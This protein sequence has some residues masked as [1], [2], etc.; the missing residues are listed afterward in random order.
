[1]AGA[2]ISWLRAH[3]DTVAGMR[4]RWRTL[5]ASLAV[6]VLAG[7]TSS[8]ED[9]AQPTLAPTAESEDQLE[10]IAERLDQFQGF[11]GDG[12]LVSP[13]VGRGST[14]VPD[15][16]FDVEEGY[17]LTIYCLADTE[18]VEV[19]I[20]GEPSGLDPITCNGGQITMARNAPD[21]SAAESD[22]L[23]SANDDDAYWLAAVTRSTDAYRAGIDEAA[24]LSGGTI[25]LAVS[26]TCTGGSESEC[27]LVNDEP[28]TIDPSQFVS[29]GVEEA[30]VAYDGAS[31]EVVHVKFDDQGTSSLQSI[32]AQVAEVG[33]EG[34][35]VVKVGEEVLSAIRVPAA[36]SG[37][38]VQIELHEDTTAVSV[39]EL[40]RGG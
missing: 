38:D 40:I 16:D 3:V 26:Q 14:K 8:S 34:R 25:E 12:V 9:D 22:I 20:D 6:L 10:A 17:V 27:M 39:L 5:A 1:M 7:C 11:V 35:L 19:R 37:S 30:Y 33:E 24:S 32:S 21:M 31:S 23:I 15:F 13:F 36:I 2:G 29:A 18:T 28:V 4:Y